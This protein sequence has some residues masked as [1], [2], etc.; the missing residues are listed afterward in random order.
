M[1]VGVVLMMMV[2]MEDVVVAVG[3]GTNVANSIDQDNIIGDGEQIQLT[4]KRASAVELRARG[5]ELHCN[6]KHIC[7]FDLQVIFG[8]RSLSIG[9]ATLD[10]LRCWQDN[11]LLTI[12]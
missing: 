4:N 9:F 10:N 11:H 5:E 6:G 2:V 1:V 3:N 7:Q 8:Y 12:E